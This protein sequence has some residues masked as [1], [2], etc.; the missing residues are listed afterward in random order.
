[1]NY[2]T[3]NIR[4]PEVD[5]LRLKSEAARNRLSLSA[6]IRKKITTSYQ[7]RRS[8]TE[9]KKMLVELAKLARENAKQLKGYKSVQVIRE[10][11]DQAKW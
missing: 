1:M 10:M 4:L 7:P 9:V 6:V 2:V 11:R 8:Q 5:Y 3:T